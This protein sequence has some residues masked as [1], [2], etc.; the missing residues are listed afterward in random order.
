VKVLARQHK[1]IVFR[2]SSSLKQISQ[3]SPFKNQ[4]PGEIQGLTFVPKRS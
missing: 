3:G 4:K 2:V 1:K